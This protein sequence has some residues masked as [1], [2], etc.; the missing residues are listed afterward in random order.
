MKYLTRHT[1][2]L[3]IT[4]RMS[5]S[6]NGNARFM[7]TVDGWHC[8]TGVDSDVADDVKNMHGKQVVAVIGTHYGVA[9]LASVELAPEIFLD[10]HAKAG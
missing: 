9:T 5:Q 3:S 2:L 4:H 7:V 1:G 10:E 6:T 8:R